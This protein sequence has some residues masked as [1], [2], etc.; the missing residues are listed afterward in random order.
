MTDER[1]KTFSERVPAGTRVRGAAYGYF[2]D[3]TPTRPAFGIK[4][5]EGTLIRHGNEI[6]GQIIDFDLVNDEL[7]T[8]TGWQDTAV[9]QFFNDDVPREVDFK[10]LEYLIDGTWV[11]YAQLMTGEM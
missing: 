1:G 6:D 3:G 4:G 11:S 7:T 9:V 10:D 2:W 5:E 8:T